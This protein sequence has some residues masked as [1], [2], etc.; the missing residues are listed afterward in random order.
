MTHP[1]GAVIPDTCAPKSIKSGDYSKNLAGSSLPSYLAAHLLCCTSN[2]CEH[3]RLTWE[4]SAPVGTAGSAGEAVD[5][6]VTKAR[7][8][9]GRLHLLHVFFLGRNSSV[10]GRGRIAST[11]QLHLWR[12][13]GNIGYE[14][15][16]RRSHC[17]ATRRLV[18]L[19]ASVFELRTS[20]RM[21]LRDQR[22]K[23][24]GSWSCCSV[25]P[26]SPSQGL[27]CVRS[28]S[29]PCRRPIA[30]NTAS[31]PAYS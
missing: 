13:C 22:R 14:L 29:F 24:E 11:P 30:K 26:V 16:R 31:A 7:R 1:L 17:P 25:E 27:P 9:S 10:C 19:R 8:G 18:Y 3:P 28:L 12:G 15:P 6:A 20:G 5:A 4:Y 2:S 21:P 23:A